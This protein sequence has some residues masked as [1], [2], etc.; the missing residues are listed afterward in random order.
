MTGVAQCLAALLLAV[1]VGLTGASALAQETSPTAPDQAES[2]EQAV[3]SADEI[4][5]D[6]SLNAV[7]ATGNVEVAYG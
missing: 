1:L 7:F 5:Y 6:E 3:I 4:S 2:N